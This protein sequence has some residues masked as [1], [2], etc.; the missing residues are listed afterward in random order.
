LFIVF[1]KEYR[2]PIIAAMNEMQGLARNNQPWRTRHMGIAPPNTQ[3]E[4]GEH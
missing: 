4:G 3:E 2:L 1:S